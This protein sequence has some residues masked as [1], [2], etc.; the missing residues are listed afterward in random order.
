[1]HSTPELPR[2]SLWSRWLT[3]LR[4]SPG[5]CCRVDKNIDRQRTQLPYEIVRKRRLLLGSAEAPP[6]YRTTAAAI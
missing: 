3:S 4:G 1:M 2:M 5:L 6:L